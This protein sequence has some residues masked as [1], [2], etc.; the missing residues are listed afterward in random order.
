MWDRPALS[1]KYDIIN[2]LLKFTINPEGATEKLNSDTFK[3]KEAKTQNELLQTMARTDKYVQDITLKIA[4]KDE[5]DKESLCNRNENG[6]CTFLSAMGEPAVP[7]RQGQVVNRGVML[8]DALGISRTNTMWCRCDCCDARF[9]KSLNA[10]ER[11]DKVVCRLEVVGKKL[12]ASEKECSP[13]FCNLK[14]PSKCQSNTNVKLKKGMVVSK[15]LDF[16]NAAQTCDDVFAKPLKSV[17][18][19][20]KSSL[21]WLQ[22]HAIQRQF[23]KSCD[24]DLSESN[25][26]KAISQFIDNHKGFMVGTEYAKVTVLDGSTPRK[27]PKPDAA[28]GSLIEV[29]NLWGPEHCRICCQGGKST[30]EKTFLP[31]ATSKNK[32]QCKDGKAYIMKSVAATDEKCAAN[33]PVSAVS[34]ES[35][36]S[37]GSSHS[38]GITKLGGE[39]LG[40]VMKSKTITIRLCSRSNRLFP[41]FG[42]DNNIYIAFPTSIN[43]DTSMIVHF[44]VSRVPYLS[45]KKISQTQRFCMELETESKTRAWS[46]AQNHMMKAVLSKSWRVPYAYSPEEFFAQETPVSILDMEIDV[47]CSDVKNSKVKPTKDDIVNIGL[48]CNCD[49][50]G[51]PIRSADQCIADNR[52]DICLWSEKNT[53][54]RL[55]SKGKTK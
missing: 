45:L 24:T 40:D 43:L 55:Q 3:S 26:K 6:D 49:Q 28:K 54:C 29:S 32:K 16:S 9:S 14:Y 15:F 13:I 11:L 42:L 18:D 53:F 23:T 51:E 22:S 5:G 25:M 20:E 8:A 46:P 7:L 2:G 30:G 4:T 37:S 19:M 12:V 36:D 52:G 31:D 44:K 34:T 33:C 50:S 38:M 35:G 27:T 41:S 39:L 47:D 21:Y 1:K 10:K 48:Y 17:E